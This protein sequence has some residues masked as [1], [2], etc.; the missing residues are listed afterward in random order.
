VT[1]VALGS[2]ADGSIF[3]VTSSRRPE[4][5]SQHTH[6]LRL[7]GRAWV[8]V[9]AWPGKQVLAACAAGDEVLCPALDGVLYACHLRTGNFRQVKLPDA[10]AEVS[11][12]AALDEPPPS[13]PA[14]KA[15][16]SCS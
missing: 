2:A 8:T 15:P 11:A 1:L 3:R 16:A 14:A 5:R 6:L 12:C 7:H 4:S 10:D 9:R 13:W